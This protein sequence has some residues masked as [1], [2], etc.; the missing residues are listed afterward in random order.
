MP[1]TLSSPLCSQ[2]FWSLVITDRGFDKNNLEKSRIVPE[3]RRSEE[4]KTL[5][6]VYVLSEIRFI[7]L[8]FNPEWVVL[9][10]K[11]AP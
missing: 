3:K 8:A 4:Q 5:Y 11:G 2:N 10:S 6:P 7:R 9:L 1:K